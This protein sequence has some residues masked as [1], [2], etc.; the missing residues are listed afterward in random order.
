MSDSVREYLRKR[1]CPDFVVSGGLARLVSAWERVAHEVASGE[2][3]DEDD[4]LNDADG[5]QIIAE[6]LPLASANE[7]DMYQQRVVFADSLIR[8]HLVATKDC[9]WGRE[10]AAKYGYARERN[11]WYYQRP[12]VVSPAWRTL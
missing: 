12:R 6:T 8:A 5:R 9:L 3:Q 4:Y 1:G 7:R 11:W 10:N 2:E